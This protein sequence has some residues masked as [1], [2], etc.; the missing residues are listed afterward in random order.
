M[1]L[2]RPYARIVAAWVALW[3][4]AALCLGSSALV[5]PVH[6]A[7]EPAGITLSPARL[8]ITVPQGQQTQTATVMV[9]NSYSQ[10]LNFAAV[11]Y[12]VQQSTDGSLVPDMSA[13]ELPFK[14]SVQVSPGTFSLDAGQSIN[15]TV[16]LTNSAQLVPGG[17]YAALL[18][19]QVPGRAGDVRLTPAVAAG[20]FIIK[21]EGAVRQLTAAIRHTDHSWVQAPGYVDVSFSNGGNVQLTPRAAVRVYD[22]AGRV[23]AQGVSNEESITVM[24][25]KDVKVRSTLQA[26]DR[27]WRPGQYRVA[28]Q[29]R[30]EGTDETAEVSLRLFVLP[31]RFVLAAGGA[32]LAAAI[33]IVGAVRVTRRYKRYGHRAVSRRQ[34]AAQAAHDKPADTLPKAHAPRRTTDGISKRTNQRPVTPP[35]EVKNNQ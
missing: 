7:D 13:G 3:V 2:H 18:V 23:I 25:G 30:Y 1:R 22:P 10:R 21:E 11:L 14:D 24:P 19:T 33:A 5:M 20:L 28:V 26:I 27:S 9:K 12:G 31:M 34:A 32:V 15:L 29:Y 8:Q 35:T 16:Q 17:Q 4:V 6:A